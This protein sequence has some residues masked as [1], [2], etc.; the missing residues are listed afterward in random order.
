M[1]IIR[2]RLLLLIT[3]SSLPGQNTPETRASFEPL[4]LF[5]FAPGRVYLA[6]SVA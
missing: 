6:I 4:P 5:S 3:F 1:A 2:L